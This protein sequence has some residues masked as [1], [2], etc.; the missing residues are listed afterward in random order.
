MTDYA[1]LHTPPWCAL[2][3]RL[4]QVHVVV[5]GIGG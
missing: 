1:C 4:W 5:V 3:Q 2:P